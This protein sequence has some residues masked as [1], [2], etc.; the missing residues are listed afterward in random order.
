M[1]LFPFRALR[2]DIS[3]KEAAYLI[4]KGK[5]INKRFV[6]CPYS[7]NKHLALF[8]KNSFKISAILLLT[9]K[10]RII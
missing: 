9:E 7:I 8:L 6:K 1:D 3:I 5:K 10:H 2:E 4:I